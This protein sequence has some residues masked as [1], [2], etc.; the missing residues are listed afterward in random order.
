VQEETTFLGVPC[1]TLRENTERP[2]TTTLG[3]NMLIGRD[4]GRLRDEV[5][6]TL[7]QPRES[8]PKKLPF[9]DGKAGERI[10]EIIARK[11]V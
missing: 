1:F 11:S 8:T 3:T 9:W 4:M 10:A 2:I 7:D 6:K 5:A